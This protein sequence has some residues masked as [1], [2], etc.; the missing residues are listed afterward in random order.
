[1]RLPSERR[2]QVWFAFPEDASWVTV[3]R[4]FPFPTTVNP[5]AVVEM[6]PPFEQYR[7][8]VEALVPADA[9]VAKIPISQADPAARSLR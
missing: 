1:M 6:D 3:V 4:A 5:F 2:V 7:E 9:G 8:S